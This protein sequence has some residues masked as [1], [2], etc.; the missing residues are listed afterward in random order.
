MAFHSTAWA[1]SFWATRHEVAVGTTNET[2][3]REFVWPL[4]HPSN[5]CGPGRGPNVWG[6]LHDFHVLMFFFHIAAPFVRNCP[7]SRRSVNFLSLRYL[8]L[9]TSPPRSV[10]IQNPFLP[11]CLGLL[12]VGASFSILEMRPKS[13]YAR[14]L[15]W[16]GPDGA[17]RVNEQCGSR[18]F[19]RG[20]VITGAIVA[21]V[22]VA[23][24]SRKKIDPYTLGGHSRII[25]ELANILLSQFVLL[26]IVRVCFLWWNV[27]TTRFPYTT[28]TCSRDVGSVWKG[29]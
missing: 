23:I 12:R 11:P 16:G 27:T 29:V 28:S 3:L 9:K 18:V 8:F 2:A 17:K 26:L 22:W 10:L 6:Y 5:P 13:R 19:K 14:I 4:C 25:F 24:P 20:F 15:D 1:T 7:W 21:R